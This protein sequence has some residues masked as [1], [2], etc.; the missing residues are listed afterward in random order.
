[1]ILRT[2]LCQQ[3]LA[4]SLIAVAAGAAAADAPSVE[5]PLTL[6]SAYLRTAEHSPA[7]R[8]ANAAYAAAILARPAAMSRLLP[9]VNASA[10]YDRVRQG[11]E[12]D[13]YGLSDLDG[14]RIH[15]RPALRLSL[16]QPL[17]RRDLFVRLDEADAIVRKAEV[18]LTGARQELQMQVA[19]AYF[20]LL[21]AREANAAASAEK[22]AIAEQLQQVRAKLDSG[23]STD[24]ELK[25]TRAQADFAA[26]GEIQAV[27]E[28]NLA[29]NRLE[30]L[31]GG[32]TP[33]LRE[34]APEALLPGTDLDGA[35]AWVRRALQHNLQLATQSLNTRLA[36]LEV[37]REDAG[38]WPTLNLVGSHYYYEAEGGI[39]G[40]H[41]YSDSRI[42]AVLNIPLF[43]GF[44]TSTRVEAAGLRL[45]EARE[46]EAMTQLD[47]SESARSGFLSL[48][49]TR[50][51]AD[52]LRLAVSSADAALSAVRVGYDVGTR[53][54]AD[55]LDAIRNR[56]RARRDLQL[57][58]YEYLLAWLQLKRS[59]GILSPADFENLDLLFKA[60]G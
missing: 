59:A 21:S 24:Y 44:G 36:E 12:G 58:R 5:V 18:Q 29:R 2:T 13:Y 33:A 7:A 49:A 31:I 60:Q 6:V 20:A 17:F 55:V 4:A 10:R 9:E 56:T 51:R 46:I 54:S 43:N 27:N 3:L 25:A 48:Q 47:V 42:G 41:E 28:V 40:S 39:T 1:M 15:N 57:A 23:L 22:R 19:R 53:T 50:L 14:T 34:L 37:D 26:A 45:L 11:I 52:A 16:E 38:H 35:E 8:A 32:P 30:R